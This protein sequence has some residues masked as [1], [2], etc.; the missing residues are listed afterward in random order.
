M[1]WK[2]AGN[3]TTLRRDTPLDGESG[4]R[5]WVSGNEGAWGWPRLGDAA[6]EITTSGGRWGWQPDM[7]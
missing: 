1:I 3:A 4:S 2:R 6:A 7:A 5:G